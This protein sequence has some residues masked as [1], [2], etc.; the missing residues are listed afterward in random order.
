[1]NQ[2]IDFN[3]FVFVKGL[4]SF[5]MLYFVL[6][7]IERISSDY[8]EIEKYQKHIKNFII[9]NFILSFPILNI[10]FVSLLWFS[11]IGIY[12]YIFYKACCITYHLN[13]INQYLS[14]R[15]T[16]ILIK[17]VHPRKKTY[18]LIAIIAL[19]MS[20][21]GITFLSDPIMYRLE[22]RSVFTNYAIYAYRNDDVIIEYCSI[23]NESNNKTG[24]LKTT[25]TKIV[26]YPGIYIRDELIE[27]SKQVSIK[28]NDN[29]V[30]PDDTIDITSENDGQH[31]GYQKLIFDYV[32]FDNDL[33]YD[34][35]PYI[36]IVL[37]DKDGYKP[38]DMNVNLTKVKS[39]NYGYRNN[40]IE[41]KN[42]E[43]DEN[44]VL[45]KLDIH[46]KNT[47]FKILKAYLIKGNHEYQLYYNEKIKNNYISGLPCVIPIKNDNELKIILYDEN[48]KSKTL[49]Y[50]FFQVI[51][52]YFLLALLIS[53]FLEAWHY[54]IIDLI[55]YPKVTLTVIAIGMIVCLFI[56]TNLYML[57]CLGYV[58][59]MM[60]TDFYRTYKIQQALILFK[61]KH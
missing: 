60:L 37:Y 15:Y 43:I 5:A 54:L 14:E 33:E 29:S 46:L 49:L 52:L 22:D 28:V 36:S 18:R 51:I 12:G 27:I 34:Y 32:Y 3:E 44:N 38:L 24:T 25:N 4:I 7:G 50:Q 59:I 58:V 10:L 55:E 45:K 8:I 30:L 9:I 48:N 2:G 39:N 31:S 47:N 61:N 17:R 19:I 53:I 11:M 35:G 16:K 41:I 42:L 21:G 1:M 57:F 56:K 20:I 26:A 6:K 40:E 23:W 13:K